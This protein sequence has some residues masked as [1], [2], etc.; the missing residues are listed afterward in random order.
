M[1]ALSGLLLMEPTVRAEDSLFDKIG[2]TT[3]LD[4]LDWSGQPVPNGDGVHVSMVEAAQSGTNKYFPDTHP[5]PTNGQFIA[6][7]DPVEP[8][9][10]PQDIE[11]IDGSGKASAGVSSHAASTVGL[12]FFGN[13]TSMA[14]RANQVTVY[15]AGDWMANTLN[16]A[17]HRD[18]H[19]SEAEDYRVQNFSW[20]SRDNSTGAETQ[21]R[22][23]LA[24]FDYL[25][26][27]YDLTALVGLNNGTG[28]LPHLLGHSYNA[29]AVGR[30]DGNHSAGFTQDFYGPGRS[31]PDLVVPTTST[32]AATAVTSSA[33]TLLHGLVAGTEAAHSET[34]RALLFAGATKEEF[35]DWSHTPTQ[36]LDE[37]YGAG[38]LNILNSWKMVHAGRAEGASTDPSQSTPLNASGWDFRSID[39]TNDWYYTFEVLDGFTLRQWS[40]ALTWNAEV[41]DTDSSSRF[42][43]EPSLANL[44]LSLYDSTT[45]LLG[46]LLDESVSTVDN[47][48][49]IYYPTELGPGTYTL[50]VSQST[51]DF[52]ADGDIDGDD[53]LLWQ[54]G[55]GMTEGALNGDGDANGDGAVDGDDLALWQE[56]L[57][58]V[59]PSQDFGLAWLSWP[60]WNPDSP[61]GVPLVASV[62]EPSTLGLLLVVLLAWSLWFRSLPGRNASIHTGSC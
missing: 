56:G 26:D 49:H 33:A 45:D 25:I 28:T 21:N 22:D 4:W 36:P 16:T 42:S 51:A 37:T 34:I 44:N 46:T 8:G 27:T 61:Q 38:E 17:N 48:E 40:I 53:F 60:E 47:L 32:S 54:R 20:I 59:P 9:Q 35:P 13:Q 6:S 62:P 19:L 3:L 52:D 23:V 31:K 58:T 39:S 30:S 43:G 50:K 41:T 18:P 2:Y 12:N 15:E 14:G 7:T 5:V 10:T 29:I 55:F 1:L 57:G 11:F 24:R